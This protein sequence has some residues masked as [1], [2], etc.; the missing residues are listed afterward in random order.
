MKII[1]VY[2]GKKFKESAGLGFGTSA[3]LPQIS[4]VTM[5]NV[6]QDSNSLRMYLDLGASQPIYPKRMIQNDLVKW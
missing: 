2:H 1:N 5:V 3:V 4:C 6:A